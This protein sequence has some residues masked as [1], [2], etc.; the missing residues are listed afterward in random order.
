MPVNGKNYTMIRVPKVKAKKLL[1]IG[2]PHHRKSVNLETNIAVDEYIHRH[3][4]RDNS[5]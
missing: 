1:G 4:Y 5:K 3:Q 2:K